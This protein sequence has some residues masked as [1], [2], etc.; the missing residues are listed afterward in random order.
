[1]VKNAVQRCD[2]IFLAH[3]VGKHH[4]N[5]GAHFEMQLAAGVHRRICR[6]AIHHAPLQRLGI[7]H[8][9]VA[10]LVV[11]GAVVAGVACRENRSRALQTPVVT[12]LAYGWAKRAK[13]TWHRATISLSGGAIEAG[14]ANHTLCRSRVVL[15]YCCLGVKT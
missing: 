10:V 7:E 1:V 5:E 12:A 2:E 13:R 15:Q 9:P 3:F 8:G 14:R 6:K 4:E 11:C